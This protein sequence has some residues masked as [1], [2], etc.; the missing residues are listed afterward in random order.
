MVGGSLPSAVW[1]RELGGPALVVP[2]GNAD[3]RNHSPNENMI[4]ER[5]FA[6]IR[7][8]AAPLAELRRAE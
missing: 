2:Y 4:V 3:Q 7:T 6:G 8:S 5:F 1:P